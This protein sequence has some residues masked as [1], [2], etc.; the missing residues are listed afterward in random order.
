[1]KAMKWVEPQSIDVPQ[2]LRAAVGGHPV[3]AEALVRRGLVARES[4]LAFLDPDRYRPTSPL[5]LPDMAVAVQRLR[6]AIERSERILVWGDFDVDGLTATALLVEALRVLG[7]TADWYIPDRHK[8]SHGVHWASLQPFLGRGVRLLLTCD[9]GVSAHEEVALA[10]SA[11]L[12]V[13]ITDHHALPPTLPEALAVVNPRRLPAEHPLHHLSGAG[14]AYKL[15]EALG[16]PEPGLDLV[17]L[18]LVADVVPQQ[19]EVRYLVQRGLQALRRA[20][21]LGIQALL[22]VAEIQPAVVDEDQISYALAPRLNA[23]GRLAEA[24]TGV[25]LFITQDLARARAIAA[26]MEAWNVRRQF[27]SRQVTQA[28][29]DQVERDPMLAS[30]PLLVA[31]N[32]QWPAGVLGIAASRLVERYGK[33]VVL[34]STPPGEAARG[35]ARSVPGVDIHAAVVAHSRL[36]GRF[37]GHPMAAG[38][39]MAADRIPELRRGLAH[40]VGQWVRGAP[41]E[42][43]LSIEAY[44]SLPELSLELLDEVARLAPFGAGNPPLVL[45][46]RELR[47]AES[48]T[49]GRTSEHRRLEVQD[50]EGHAQQAVWWQSADLPL[51]EGSFDLAYVLRAN[52]F[53]G[54]R[55][56]QLEWVDARWM[57]PPAVEVAGA[58]LVV[59]V[60]D[61]RTLAQPLPTLQAL[62]QEGTMQLWAEAVGVADLPA[63]RR[64][65]LQPSE[66]LVVWTAPPGPRVWQ[67]A[68]LRARPQRV[69]VFAVDPQLDRLEA[70]LQRL[71]GVVKHALSAYAGRLEWQALA[72]AMAHREDT[73]QAGLRWL[74][75]RGQVSVLAESGEGGIIARALGEGDQGA[76]RAAR[77]ALQ[78]MLRETAAYRAYFREVDVRRLVAGDR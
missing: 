68:L 65:E 24:A 23:L 17:A 21:R 4:A 35:S 67:E 78:E 69:Y 39:S 60:A 77:N 40:T 28:A 43:E 45:A 9:T 51:P 55:T 11:G 6:L 3:V 52:E 49:I 61:Y 30:Q 46:T 38:F 2:E 42:R 32:P 75:A 29:R 8:E 76:E 16:L 71:A 47:V 26:E 20:E 19:G 41:P 33:P 14:V 34:I 37:G 15:A 54:Q 62:W 58:P 73:V 31:A 48:R 27:L 44:F 63:R 1:M 72:A 13:L 10:R 66:E 57:E 7:A 50:E 5:E 12:D 25:E 56:L 36:L 18:G 22:E 53:Q 74:A 59:D 70:F 64:H